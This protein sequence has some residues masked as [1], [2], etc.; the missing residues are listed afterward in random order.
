MHSWVEGERSETSPGAKRRWRAAEG[1]MR[2][3]VY[4][5]SL[6][7]GLWALLVIRSVF[8][9]ECIGPPAP[10]FNLIGPASMATFG[11][12]PVRKCPRGTNHRRASAK[13]M[14][15]SPPLQLRTLN[16][17]SRTLRFV[18]RKRLLFAPAFA[19]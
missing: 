16:S 19:C 17:E 8:E 13:C 9:C 2:Q 15:P 11:F 5:K 3:L 10:S 18:S 7:G 1:R 4:N 12:R 14:P 6:L